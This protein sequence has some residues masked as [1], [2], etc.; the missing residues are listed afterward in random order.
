MEA[1]SSS[2]AILNENTACSRMGQDCKIRSMNSPCLVEIGCRCI[3]PDPI[4]HIGLNHGSTT[5]LISI[6]IGCLRNATLATSLQEHLANRFIDQS[7]MASIT[8]MDGPT[9]TMKTSAIFWHIEG[10]RLFEKGQNALRPPT[11]TPQARLPI[12]E[13]ARVSSYP[14]HGVDG[15]RTSK[16]LT[17]RA[18]RAPVGHWL[19]YTFILPIS[20]T[21]LQPGEA[22]KG[23]TNMVVLVITTSFD[24]ENW[25]FRILTKTWCHHTSCRSCTNDHVVILLGMAN[26]LLSPRHTAHG[27][28]K[29]VRSHA[30]RAGAQ[31]YKQRSLK[32]CFQ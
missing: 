21:A 19:L 15:A 3:I 2:S 11:S 24:Q 14:N 5:L 16:Q 32:V 26:C 12:V 25:H 31:G 30:S 10:F 29:S 20:V 1:H 6:V 28:P 9:V 27:T 23:R 18:A 13:G 22:E 7:T 4:F 8:D 17:S